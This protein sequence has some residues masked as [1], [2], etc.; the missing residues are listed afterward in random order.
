MVLVDCC[1]E[2]KEKSALT[3]EIKADSIFNMVKLSPVL[4]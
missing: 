2:A 3:R 4:S 1:K